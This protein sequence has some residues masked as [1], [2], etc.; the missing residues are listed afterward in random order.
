VVVP[1]AADTV[2]L[3]QN[4]F[5]IAE[6]RFRVLVDGDNDR[7]DTVIAEALTGCPMTDLGKGL[8][9][10]RILSVVVVPFHS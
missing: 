2:G 4:E 6:R 10:G 8:D 3:V 7:L 5:P 9:P 1:F